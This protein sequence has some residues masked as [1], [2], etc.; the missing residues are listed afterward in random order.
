MRAGFYNSNAEPQSKQEKV[1]PP[2]FAEDT[3]HR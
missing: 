3:E 1:Y 2:N